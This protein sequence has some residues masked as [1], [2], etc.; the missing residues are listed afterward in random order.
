MAYNRDDFVRIK[1]EYETKKKNAVADAEARTAAVHA[2]YGDIKE[3]DDKLR[4]TGLNILSESMKGKDGLA[5]RIAAIEK[6]NAELCKKR[7]ALLEKYGLPADCTDVKYECTKCSDTGYIGINMCDCFKAALAKSA[8]ESSGLGNLLKD[9]SFET[10]DLSYYLD[11]KQNYEKMEMTVK[12]CK[13]Y[14]DSFGKGSGSLIFLGATGLGKTHLS[15]SIARCV[16]EKGFSVSY[17][18]APNVFGEF[19]K[20][21]FKDEKGLTDK[22]FESDLLI[23]D[24]LGTEMHTQFTVSCLYNLINTRLNAGKSTIISTNLSHD[25][26]RRLYTDRITSRILG[27]FDPVM[28]CG[29]DVRLQ[30]LQR[31]L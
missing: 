1:Q 12:K 20:E 7:A 25:D 30:K 5:E 28:F 11:S 14:A 22:Y 10:F 16:I 29:K 3:I 19:G 8:Y 4:M 15:T 18:S 21:Q 2:Q 9:Q 26:M 17:D 13:A 27:C 24:D 6:T 31:S 23:L